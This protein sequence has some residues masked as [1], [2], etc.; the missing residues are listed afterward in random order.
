LL[1]SALILTALYI[2]GL[3]PYLDWSKHNRIIDLEE[4]PLG[5]VTLQGVVT[6]VDQAN[7]RFWIQDESGAIAID[8]SPVTARVR[9]GEGV[10]IQAR[11]SHIF[12]SKFGFASIGLTDYHIRV[13]QDRAP[14]PPA[15]PARLTGLPE[16]E[17]NGILVRVEGVLHSVAHRGDHTVLSLG[18][19][20][21]EVAVVVPNAHVPLDQW[22]NATLEVTGVSD[23]RVDQGGSLDVG[24]TQIWVQKQES[25]RKIQDA[26]GSIPLYSLQDLYRSQN[27]D[28][29]HRVRLRGTVLKVEAD[30]FVLVEDAWG[31][32]GCRAD[33]EGV[34]PAGTPVEVAG[35]QVRDGMRIDLSHCKLTPI[36]RSEL[37]V[38]S[39]TTVLTTVEAIKHL[40]VQE[41]AKALP[42]RLTGVANYVDS[43]WR[44]LFFQDATGGIFVKYAGA[45]RP[46][47][48]G[49]RITMVGVTNPGDFAPVILGPKIEFLGN[50]HLP[51]PVQMGPRAWL[52]ELDSLFVEIEGIVHPLPK[53]QNPTH[54]SFD[55][56]TWLGPIH[57]N[58]APD[59]GGIAELEK[60][61]D[62]KVRIRGLCGEVFNS[63]RQLIGLQLAV[64]SPQYVQILD[65]P[66]LKPFAMPAIP[67][68]HLL[69]ASPE[70][71]FDHRVRVT[72]SVT[73]IGNGFFY[74]QDT[75]GG[76]RVEAETGGLRLSDRADVVGYASVGGYSPVLTDA[77]VRVLDH[78]FPVDVRK[79]TSETATGGLFDSQIVSIQGTL[80][81]VFNSID[82]KTLVVRSE[83]RTF[84]AVL[85]LTKS[86]QSAPPLQEGSV[87]R[88]TG[89]CT[90]QLKRSSVYML[91]T[92]DP[93]GFTLAIRSP[94]DIEILKSASWWNLRHITAMFGLLVAVAF[95]GV[96]WIA[97]LRRRIRT[98][99][100]A[101]QHANEKTNAIRQL[102]NAM[103][104]VTSQRRFTSRVSAGGTDEI[105]HLSLEFNKMLEELQAGEAARTE[106][107]SKLRHLA[108]TDE[109]TGLPNRRLFADRLLQLLAGAERSNGIVALVYIDLD[110]FKLVNDSLGH[111][112][113]D[114]L[115]GQVAERLRSR[116]R[117]QDTLARLGGDEF[118]VALT[119]LNKG[120][121]AELVGNSLLQILATPF[122]IRSHEIS[123]TASL[124]VSIYPDNSRE[125]DELLQQ[126]DSAMYAAKRSG[127]SRVLFF[128]PE[129]G[130]QVRERMSLEN[131]LRGAISRGEITLHYQPEFDLSSHRLIRFEALARWT[132][133]TL[134]S[135]PPTKFIPIAEE[136][137][138]IIPLGMY[139]LERA[140]ADAVTWQ[141]ISPDP[142]QVAVNVS[143][144]QFARDGFVDQV[145]E[146][147]R[148]SGLSAKLLQ[149]EL[150]E[151]VMLAG[152]ERAAET[153]RRLGALGVSIA[154]DDFGTGYSCFSYLPRL[155]FNALKIDRSF[156]KDLGSVE[157][158]AMIQSLVTLA[159]NLDM[160]VVVEGIETVQQLETI[161][162]M[163]GNQ[164]QGYLLGRPTPDPIAEI[165]ARKTP[166]GLIANTLP[167]AHNESAMKALAK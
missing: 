60:L 22:I 54:L 163:G 101:L 150:T 41:A 15:A 122:T 46:I 91:I 110:G 166:E 76:T 70:S 138:L 137:G 38:K 87:L 39:P 94:R 126:A 162:S 58:V 28:D 96:G 62:A 133:P 35:F 89:I 131:Q 75:S 51:K 79:V 144:I 18:N 157:M 104:E 112:I 151:S 143:S 67:I 63:K 145:A 84:N 159:H 136:T 118:V 3:R 16:K 119:Q 155:P 14:L 42:A 121:D 125:A 44:Q 156:V 116:I 139:I 127:K 4:L 52:G 26:P 36:A 2:P 56:Y 130:S 154:I 13:T 106:A 57:V 23:A 109:L 61:V 19:S 34:V 74:V 146:V 107:E 128:T 43:N 95:V 140:C 17:K 108:L 92:K 8:A 147:L 24:G 29:S 103:G 10:R 83:G 135:I 59:F 90:A 160:Q 158:K 105:A 82:S 86:D 102:T 100:A 77:E 114:V 40:S 1:A 30:A 134:G 98:Q 152:T 45:T 25:V 93:V 48:P 111:S 11:K 66:N 69:R 33:V 65:R 64:Y 71:S 72:G 115:L 49:E 50:G 153:M 68:S 5:P 81:S 85:D 142:I 167:G 149:I 21:R 165:E 78:N 12:D 161:R 88:L 164:V 32:A 141:E 31:V 27:E 97:L 47:V 99:R 113:G 20:G 117:K 124:G 53:Q 132:H 80:L 55:L 148:Q 73:M 123:I 6:Y 37:P 129:I 7:E 9:Y 120:Q